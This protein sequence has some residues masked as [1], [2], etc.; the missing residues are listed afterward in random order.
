M[1]SA[2]VAGIVIVVLLVAAASVAVGVFYYRRRSRTAVPQSVSITYSCFNKIYEI[3]CAKN[4]T[5]TVV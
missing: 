5:E 4:I 3:Y 2:A 1:S